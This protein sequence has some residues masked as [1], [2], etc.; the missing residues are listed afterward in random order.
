MEFLTRVMLMMLAPLANWDGSPCQTEDYG[1][2][3][4]LTRVK[5]MMHA[6]GWPNH[7]VL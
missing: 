4:T 5:L 2:V 1:E 7:R 3:D 6:P